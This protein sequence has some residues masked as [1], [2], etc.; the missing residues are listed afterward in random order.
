LVPAFSV[1]VPRSHDRSST[2]FCV[3]VSRAELNV[4][5]F[6]DAMNRKVT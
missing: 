3:G 2:M 5:A 6:G 4:M 1:C